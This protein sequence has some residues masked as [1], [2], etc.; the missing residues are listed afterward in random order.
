MTAHIAFPDITLAMIAAELR[1]EHGL[2][3]NLYPKWIAAGRIAE[4]EARHGLAV[5]DAL[6]SD[7]PR[8]EAPRRPWQE[9]HELS[10]A[11]RRA[12]L[13]N[14]LAYRRRLYP[15]FIAAGRFDAAEGAARIAC[16]TCL[17]WIFEDGFDWRASNG[18]HPAMGKCLDRT[19]AEDEALREWHEYYDTVMAARFPATQEEMPL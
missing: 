2:R 4:A 19:R 8:I 16:L 3:A 1:R 15:E 9:T 17:L 14:E 11:T 18:A 12:A 7:I 10:W 5:F 13:A 6:I